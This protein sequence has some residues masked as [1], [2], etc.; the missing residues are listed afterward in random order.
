MPVDQGAFVP[1]A[2]SNRPID[3]QSRLGDLIENVPRGFDCIRVSDVP[4]LYRDDQLTSVILGACP[5][6]RVNYM[7]ALYDEVYFDEATSIAFNIVAFSKDLF[8]K[9]ITKSDE[10]RGIVCNILRGVRAGQRGRA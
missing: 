8:G 9:V 3:R 1:K 7:R 5:R 6:D 2:E 4:M 10:G